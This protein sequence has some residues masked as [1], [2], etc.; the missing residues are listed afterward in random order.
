MSSEHERYMSLAVHE[1]YKARQWGEVPVGAV[2]VHQKKILSRAHNMRER[3]QDPCAH[4]EIIALR[5]AA[6]RLGSWRLEDCSLYVTL[7]PCLMCAGALVQA[8]IKECIYGAVDPKAGFIT[9]LGTMGQHPEL[10]HQFESLGGVLGAECSAILKDFFRDL[11]DRK[12]RTYNVERWPS[13]RR[14]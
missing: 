12:K 13:C 6:Q 7:E 1:A 2:V 14:R 9:S 8:R 11:R 3:D 5:R 10:N 4:A